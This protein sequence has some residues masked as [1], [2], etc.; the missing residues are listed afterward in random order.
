MARPFGVQHSGFARHFGHD[1]VFSS[2]GRL[3][4][5]TFV[6]GHCAVF[7]LSCLLFL[8]AFCMHVFGL[9]RG[10]SWFRCQCAA[11]G[12]DGQT[13]Q[14]DAELKG[15][16]DCFRCGKKGDVRKVETKMTDGFKNEGGQRKKDHAD[17]EEKM[18]RGIES[19]ALKMEAGFKN[20]EGEKFVMN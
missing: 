13:F 18:R 16:V 15:T 1:G 19:E 17:L 20:E 5:E 7:H 10:V 3:I 2:N 8:I 9:S 12:Y 4:V 14:L 6:G 11:H